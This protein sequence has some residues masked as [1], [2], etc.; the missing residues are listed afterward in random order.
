MKAKTLTVL[1]LL[2]SSHVFSQTYYGKNNFGK[3]EILNDSICTAS[4]L[5]GIGVGSLIPW[6]DTIHYYK[7]GDTIFIS[8]NL[9][10]FF[11]ISNIYSK[12][13]YDSCINKHPMI[14]KKYSKIN[15]KY[16][17][18]G[19]SVIEFNN[20]RNYID[21][22]SYIYKGDI[23]VIKFYT[24]YKRFVWEGEETKKFR[25]NVV[26]FGQQELFFD[27]FPLLIRDNKIIPIDKEKNFKSWVENGFYFPVMKKSKIVKEYNTIVEWT[28]GLKG[29]PNCLG[30]K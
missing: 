26:G 2:I 28:L 14:V 10:H 24:S 22:E 3:F 27:N 11:E 9:K 19:E 8:T 17:F 6:T 1:F 29:L 4:F 13:Y 12:K 16:K 30:I 23:F 25:V 20:K 18:E 15:G 5:S 21:F 7:R